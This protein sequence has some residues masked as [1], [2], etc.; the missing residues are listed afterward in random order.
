M[1]G[2]GHLSWTQNGIKESAMRDLEEG[3]VLGCEHVNS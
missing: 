3:G 2:G 1:S